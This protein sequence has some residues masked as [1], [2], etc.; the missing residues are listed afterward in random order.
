LMKCP[1]VITYRVSALTAWLMR[2][3]GR[4]YLPYIG[5]PNI[6]AGEFIVPELLQEEATPQK[7]AQAVLQVYRDLNRRH[8][9]ENRFTAIHRGL[10]QNTS[11]RIIEA[12]APYLALATLN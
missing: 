7:L 11:Q 8:E 10:R 9:L 6:L 3:K 2:R 5:L 1:M 12:L 4:G